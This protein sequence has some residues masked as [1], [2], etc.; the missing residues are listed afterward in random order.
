MLHALKEYADTRKLAFEPGFKAKTVRWPLTF[1]RAGVFLEVRDLVSEQGGGRGREFLRCPHLS[2]PELRAGGVGCRHFL[3]DTVDVVVP[4]AQDK[5]DDQ[6]RAKHTHFLQCMENAC[7]A[8]PDL[9]PVV[10]A[11]RCDRSLQQMRA[12]LE[13]GKAKPAE[14]ATFAVLDSEIPILVERQ[15]WWHWWRSFRGK[16]SCDEQGQQARG[17]TEK[18]SEPLMRCL[19]S[20]R[21]VRPAKTPPRISGLSDVGGLQTGDVL[22]SFNQPSFRS[23]GLEQATNAAMSDNM[24]EMCRTALDHLVKCPLL[25]LDTLRQFRPS[26]APRLEGREL[27]VPPGEHPGMVC[28]PSNCVARRV[29]FDSRP[30]VYGCSECLW[31]G[32]R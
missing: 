18:P 24:A 25:C 7:E 21:L 10:A 16:L 23:F 3:V 9:K 15:T 12:K 2:S 13:E 5:L 31:A 17:V 28:S 4:P 29:I 11:L 20:G 14:L 27:R 26:D 1:D 32:S 30:E 8:E 22:V 6:L 19:L